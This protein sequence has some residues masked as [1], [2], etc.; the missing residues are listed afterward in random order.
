MA[1]TPLNPS[2][3]TP[4]AVTTDD[5]E[6]PIPPA[7]DGNAL[8]GSDVIADTLRALDIPYI[9]LN[10]GASYRGLHDSLVNRLGNTAPQMLL[11]LHEEHAVAI[12]QG[13]AKV[14]EKPML[15]AVHSNVGLL[16]AT[17]AIFDAW[18]DR[19][20]VIVLGATGPVDAAL[21]RPWIDWIHTSRDQG[22]LVR[23]YVKWDDQPASPA[24]ARESVLRA[25]W[26]AETAPKG[27]VYVNF[28]CAMQESV[29]EQP[30]P[31]IDPRRFMPPAAAGVS[32]AQIA[33]LKAKLGAAKKPVI[34]M[35]RVSR[36]LAAWDARVALAECLNARVLTSIRLASAFPTDHPLHVGEPIT[37]LHEPAKAALLEADLIL[38]LDWI[39]VAGTLQSAFGHLS[40]KAEIVQIS[41]DHHLHN[42]WSL[43]H[44]ALPPVDLFVAAEPD[45]VV[46][47]LLEAF[48]HA[49]I[50][51]SRPLSREPAPLP[52]DGSGRIKTA[53]LARSLRQALGAR[54]ASLLHLPVS[55]RG[56]DWTFRHPLDFIGGE[57]GGGIGGGPGIAVG[58]ALALRGGDR[59]PVA[60]LGDGDFMMGVSAIWTAAHYRIPLL[61]VVVNNQS[62]YHDEAHQKHVAQVR[63]RPTENKWIGMRM[64]DP[65]IDIAKIAEAQGALGIGPVTS[66]D[67]L[68]AVFREA[69]AAVE[70]GRVVV[71]DVRAD[72]D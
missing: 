10:P 7:V 19:V 53:T 55:W 67:D 44:Q 39:D 40:P 9:A 34:L 56:E 68:P 66:A 17:M 8:F 64:T 61:I 48:G 21:R 11:C 72:T 30:L 49:S 42:G 60:F 2:S 51:K 36:G 32:A 45:A 3:E 57:G 50:P 41:L 22:A 16:H 58:A 70:A 31:P 13:Y 63:G 4:E 6:R 5:I 71:I 15:A 47:V 46:P 18:C 35:G 27:P 37:R 59:L 20:P 54:A 25:A 43:D 14:T 28:D 38:S 33:Q 62:F 24:A 29:L 65:E 23:N 52:D 69:I 26:I 1:D 12:A